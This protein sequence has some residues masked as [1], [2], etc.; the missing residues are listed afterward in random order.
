MLFSI[1]FFCSFQSFFLQDFPERPLRLAALVPV[2]LKQNMKKNLQLLKQVIMINVFI[3]YTV[4]FGLYLCHL[5]IKCFMVDE[6]LQ[7]KNK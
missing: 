3:K 4:A 1:L 6:I 7:L 2:H 5:K